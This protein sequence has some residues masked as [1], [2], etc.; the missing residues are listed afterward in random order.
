MSIKT[1]IVNAELNRNAEMYAQLISLKYNTTLHF[2]ND[3]LQPLN[4][5]L[6]ILTDFKRISK[7][8]LIKNVGYNKRLIKRNIKKFSE[9]FMFKTSIGLFTNDDDI[10]DEYIITFVSKLLRSIGYS[11]IRY[12]TNYIS[13]K[14]NLV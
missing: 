1:E 4:I 6:R 5:K 14:R 11:F 8:L 12:G 9:I 2:I 10:D 13:I 3:W 7:N